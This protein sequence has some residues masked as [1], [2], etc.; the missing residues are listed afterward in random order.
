ME[1]CENCIK[2]FYC[3]KEIGTIFGVCKKDYQLDPDY[4]DDEPLPCSRPCNGE[5]RDGH[6]CPYEE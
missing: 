4:P 2:R 5:C 6:T 3:K 1:S